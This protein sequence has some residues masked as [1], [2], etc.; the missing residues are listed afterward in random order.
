MIIEKTNKVFLQITL[1]LKEAI[2]CNGMIRE[3]LKI[4]DEVTIPANASNRIAVQRM[5]KDLPANKLRV[6]MT[7]STGG[8][9]EKAAAY[10]KF[11]KMLELTAS[12]AEFDKKLYEQAGIPFEKRWKPS[13]CREM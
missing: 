12:G 10:Q 6:L 5:F 1:G 2:V 9:N 7:A 3:L 13:M 11:S 8:E 4:Y